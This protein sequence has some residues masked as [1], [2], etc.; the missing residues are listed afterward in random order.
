MGAQPARRIPRDPAGAWLT[1]FRPT[2]EARTRVVCFPH[3]GGSASFYREWARALPGD[4]ELVAVQYPGRM[5]RFA[6]PR[7]DTMAPMA[8]AITAALEGI[9]PC[10]LFGHSMGAAIAFEVAMR[11]ERSGR[12]PRHLFVSGRSGPSSHVQGRRHLASDS[13]LIAFIRMLGGTDATLFDQPE[14]WP[15]ILPVLRS[16][17]KLSET[18]KPD[19]GARVSCPLTAMGGEDDPEVEV[20]RVATW[21]HATTSRFELRIFDGDHFYLAAHLPEVLGLLTRA[22]TLSGVP[23]PAW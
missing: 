9:G 11:L 1:R 2:P 18:W 4:V 3:G 22:A 8:D 15:M 16:D 5:N 6:E 7:I 14:M 12:R 20:H 17:F 23:R 10:V 13:A 19:L 21:E